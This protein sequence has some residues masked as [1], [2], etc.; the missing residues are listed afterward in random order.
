MGGITSPPALSLMPWFVQF[1]RCADGPSARGLNSACTRPKG[2]L[3]SAGVE[4]GSHPPDF[5]PAR[6]A[7]IPCQR[8]YRKKFSPEIAH[9][10]PGHLEVAATRERSAY[11][12]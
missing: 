1:S 3:R 11:H 9:H 12:L 10:L 6:I 7:A 4:N 2:R 8:C 5:R